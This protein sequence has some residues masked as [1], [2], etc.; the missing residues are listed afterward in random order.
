MTIHVVVR[1]DQNQH[2]FI[3]ASVVGLFRAREDADAF[4]RSSAHYARAEGR[5]VFGDDESEPH[6]DV[7]WTVEP[8][9]V[10]NAGARNRT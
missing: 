5:V 6:W 8:H 7:S 9:A 1:E 10:H 4:I 2:G 3:D